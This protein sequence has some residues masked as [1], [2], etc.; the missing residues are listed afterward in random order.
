MSLAPTTSQTVVT[1]SHP[2]DALYSLHSRRPPSIFFTGPMLLILSDEG[3]GQ[4]RDNRY[5]EQ[6][7]EFCTLVKSEQLNLW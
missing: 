7:T 5:K 2:R 3:S 4:T 6:L 1:T